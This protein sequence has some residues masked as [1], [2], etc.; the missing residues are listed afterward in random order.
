MLK[1]SRIEKMFNLRTLDDAQLKISLINKISL[2]N[3][4]FFYEV[5]KHYCCYKHSDIFVLNFIQEWFCLLLE[6][7]KHL[8][9]SCHSVKDVL[10]NSGLNIS[11]E[12]DIFNAGD[13]WIKHDPK[14]RSKFALEIIKLVR[15]PLISST[16]LDSLLKTENSFSKCLSSNEY[17]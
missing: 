4:C 12:I 10:S 9:M 3:V 16:S 11:T 15:L 7:N 17:I 8:D 13:G 1:M 6:N 2:D 14:E 5:M